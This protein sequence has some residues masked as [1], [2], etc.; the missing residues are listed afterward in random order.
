MEL[1]LHLFCRRH[2]YLLQLSQKGT[3]TCQALLSKFIE[4]TLLLCVKHP[5]AVG[6]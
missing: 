3:A 4:D 6:F 2:G 1:I 5:P